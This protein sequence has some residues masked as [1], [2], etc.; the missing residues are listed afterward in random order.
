MA[1]ATIQIAPVRTQ[2]LGRPVLVAAS[3]ADLRGPTTGTVEL[4]L[5]LFWSAPDA[6]FS[7]DDPGTR[8]QM[9]ETVVREARHP[10]DLARYLDGGML[11]ALWPVMHLP[12]HV[13]QAWEDQHPVLRASSA[14]AA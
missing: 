7:L 2:Y 4:P 13:K 5:H 10:G 1:T 12:R 14:A 9:Y 3:L 6:T 11:V 8:R